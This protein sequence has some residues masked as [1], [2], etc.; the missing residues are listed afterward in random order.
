[1]LAGAGGSLRRL[2]G[3]LEELRAPS[4]DALDTTQPEGED[5]PEGKD[6]PEGE[7]P[8]APADA[9][10]SPLLRSPGGRARGLRMSRTPSPGA[11]GRRA[12]PADFHSTESSASQDLSSRE[13][14]QGLSGPSGLLYITSC[15][16]DPRTLCLMP[17]AGHS[18]C[19]P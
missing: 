10:A 17:S 7:D 12:N 1:M 9:Q 18:L 6:P 3:Q 19:C 4:L 8:P 13:G 2:V 11:F 14:A 15:V 16:E 5:P